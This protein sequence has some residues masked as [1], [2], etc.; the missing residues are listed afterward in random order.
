[1]LKPVNLLLEDLCDAAYVW[2]IL[3]YRAQRNS[4]MPTRFVGVPP[5]IPER[6]YSSPAAGTLERDQ[7]TT[8]PNST[9]LKIS[10]MKIIKLDAMLAYAIGGHVW[11]AHTISLYIRLEN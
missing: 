10:H 8:K 3:Y 4:P 9:K 6:D 11:L 2:F 5:T 7:E 1:M